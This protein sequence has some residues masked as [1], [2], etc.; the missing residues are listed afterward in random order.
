[1]RVKAEV[2]TFTGAGEDDWSFAEPKE[3][4]FGKRIRDRK[5]TRQLPF[6]SLRN[7]EGRVGVPSAD[8]IYDQM[9]RDGSAA[10]AFSMQSTCSYLGLLIAL[11]N[12]MGSIRT[13]QN[14]RKEM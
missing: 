12:L 8:I 1:V 4:R 6:L 13:Y 3:E 9:G 14:A 7:G 11:H 2:H 10:N 5:K